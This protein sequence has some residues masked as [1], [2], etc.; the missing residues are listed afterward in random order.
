[1]Q[2][3]HDT[4][5]PRLTRYYGGASLMGN[6][7]FPVDQKRGASYKGIDPLDIT[8][9]EFKTAYSGRE[10]YF[11]G[12]YQYKGYPVVFAYVSDGSQFQ[13]RLFYF[14]KSHAVWR[15][16]P[17]VSGKF[18]KAFQEF[19]CDLPPLLNLA[20]MHAFNT[21]MNQGRYAEMKDI[22]SFVDAFTSPFP[23]KFK[24][25]PE[26]F[27]KETIMPDEGVLQMHSDDISLGYL[28]I[29]ANILRKR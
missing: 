1:M 17:A 2:S 12:L 16:A 4:S 22:E 29:P 8:P 25:R 19:S 21:P 7:A 6:I 15:V 10:I 18:G 24:E 14:S 13:P 27:D 11:S 23:A 3:S 9:I 28:K 5:Y 20:M 26:A